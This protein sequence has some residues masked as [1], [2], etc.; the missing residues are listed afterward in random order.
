MLNHRS[1][2]CYQTTVPLLRLRQGLLSPNSSFNYTIEYA[3]LLEFGFAGFI[4]VGAIAPDAVPFIGHHIINMFAVVNG[5]GI[6]TVILLSHLWKNSAV[7]GPPR[8]EV[9]LS[10]NVG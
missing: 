2:A 7:R 5:G 9:R 10:R 3:T 6:E 4:H 1:N 8:Y